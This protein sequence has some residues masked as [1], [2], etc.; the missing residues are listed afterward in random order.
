[1]ANVKQSGQFFTPSYLVCDIL[2]TAGYVENNIRKKHV[3]DNSCGDGA[4]I[5]VI[6]QRYILDFLKDSNDAN[7]LKSELETYIHGIE[8]DSVAYKQCI[9]NLNELISESNLSDI[10]WDIHNADTLTINQFNGKMDFVVGNPPYVR[11]HNLENY[12]LVKQ[13]KFAEGGMTDLYLV[14]FE[15]GFNMLKESGKLCYITP[16]SWI[17]SVAGTA[18]RKY[19][20][21]HHNL[22][23]LIDLE[24]YQ[25]FEATTYTMISLFQKG[26]K[27]KTF[28]YC[29][30]QPHCILAKENLS[31][32]E[33]FIDGSIYLTSK[34]KLNEL[35]LIF[36]NHQKYVQV[37]NGFATLADNVFIADEFPFKQHV[38]PVIKAS[39]GK[40]CKAFFP[41]DK[42]GKPLTKE[43]IFSNAKISKYLE[44]NTCS[45]LKGKTK[46]QKPEWYLFGRTQALK[47]VYQNK[48]SINT[49]ISNLNSI[50]FN[51][52]PS[53]YGIYSGLYILTEVKENILQ[54]F[55]ISN[56]FIE[57]V[58]ILKKYKSGGYYTF[59]SKDL[60]KYLNYKISNF[61]NNHHA[62]NQPN[63][64]TSNF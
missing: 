28:T 14:F 18:L 35:R 3:I 64:F 59:S 13:F 60:E 23:R 43:E 44:K 52:V 62:I 31:I 48:Y 20:L 63:L 50:K 40:W 17:N 27:H 22:V 11:V 38:I 2:N 9:E 15:I 25:A 49:I 21:Q 32:E 41:Y 5:T 36:T 4:F 12:E 55:I 24:H 29:T 26:I 53:G 33:T 16:S 39:T 61:Y 7:L 30:Y 54:R 19:I 46:E 10:K 45:L 6:V 56:E 37:K 57:Y 58:S 8:L 47:D 1:M 34:E 42:N 51:K